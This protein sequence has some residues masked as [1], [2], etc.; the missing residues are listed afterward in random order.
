MV[1]HKHILIILGFLAISSLFSA[2]FLYDPTP[3]LTGYVVINGATKVSTDK[4]DPALVKEINTGNNNP[5]VIL[6]LDNSS[7]S[8]KQVQQEVITSLEKDLV[9]SDSSTES[10][11]ASTIAKP[12]HDQSRE[13]DLT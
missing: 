10:I 13:I 3:S 11:S 7:T 9:V 2:V 6:I 1:E 8:L 12:S 4:L 5:K